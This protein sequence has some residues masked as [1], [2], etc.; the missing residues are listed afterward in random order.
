MGA[1]TELFE[2]RMNLT[3][4]L[5]RI[6]RDN[7]PV[8]VPRVEGDPTAG[9][10]SVPGGLQ[11]SDGFEVELNGNPRKGWDVSFAFNTV[12]SKFKDKRDPFYGN[13]PGGTADWQVS[14]YSA[15]EIQTG[16]ARGFGFGGTYYEIADRGVSAF[17]LGTIPGYKRIDA[18]LFYKGFRDIE[19]NLVVRNI[20]DETYIEGA[21]RPGAIAF[22]GSPTAALLSVKYTMGGS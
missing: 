22:F 8:S 12:D 18:H 7:V 5:Y 1:K 21:D 13:Q 11:R 16:P 2:R 4:A 9:T 14:L 17:Q 20:T 19:I 10:Y 15:Y 3:T 6:D